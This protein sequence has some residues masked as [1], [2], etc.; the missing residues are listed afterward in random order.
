MPFYPIKPTLPPPPISKL[1]K[2]M[3]YFTDDWKLG[4]ENSLST[5]EKC[6]WE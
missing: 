1:E 6:I 5:L 3:H 4:A 2:K